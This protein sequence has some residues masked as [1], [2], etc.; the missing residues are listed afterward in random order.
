MKQWINESTSQW[1]KEPNQWLNETVN[2]WI[3]HYKEWVNHSVNESMK[4]RGIES[5]NQWVNELINHRIKD[6][7]IYQWIDEP[8]SQQLSRWISQRK[9][10][11]INES[12]HQSQNQWFS[13]SVSQW[14]NEAAN[15]WSTMKHLFS[16]LL[17]FLSASYLGCSALNCLPPWATSSVAS[18]T[19]FFSSRNQHS[20]FCNLQLQF[21]IV[22]E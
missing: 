21:R 12:M 14:I 22:Q 11:W 6:Q 3:N 7:W 8:T 16:Q 4:Q 10:H 13:K 9:K 19:Q 20:A 17:L 1:A 2:Q 15:Q 5:V 18:A